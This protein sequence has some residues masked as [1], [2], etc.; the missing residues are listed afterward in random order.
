MSKTRLLVLVPIGLV[1]ATLTMPANGSPVGAARLAAPG[2]SSAS[3]SPKPVYDDDHRLVVTFTTT[4][5][6]RPGKGLHRTRLYR[7]AGRRGV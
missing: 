2:V 6:A 4:G 7:W 1:A 3:V 5:R